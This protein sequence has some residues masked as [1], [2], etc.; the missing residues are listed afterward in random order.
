M[1]LIDENKKNLETKKIKRSM[2][3]ANVKMVLEEIVQIN[4]I[5]VIILSD[6]WTSN[7]LTAI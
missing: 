5:K 3:F 2:R 1:T 7:P 6:Y 4:P